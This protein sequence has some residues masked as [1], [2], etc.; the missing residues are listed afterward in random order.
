MACTDQEAVMQ[1]DM[2]RCHLAAAAAATL[3]AL[4]PDDAVHHLLCQ[5]L[6]LAPAG[7]SPGQAA[8]DIPPREV[9]P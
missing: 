6:S 4:K 9:H 7:P 8:R 3:D 2:R 1:Y 5:M